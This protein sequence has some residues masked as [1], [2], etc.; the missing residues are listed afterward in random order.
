MPPTKIRTEQMKVDTD[1]TMAANSDEVV[2]SQKAVVTYV[3]GR[4]VSGPEGFGDNY[5]ISPIISANQILVTLAAITGSLLSFRIG[6]VERTTTTPPTVTVPAGVV[7][8][9]GVNDGGLPGRDVDL[10][11]YIGWRVSDTSIFLAVSRIPWAKTFA[12]VNYTAT[13]ERTAYYSGAA[14]AGSNQMECIGRI[15]AQNSGTASY[16]WSIPNPLV[17]SRPIYEAE[18][19]IWTPIMDRV[20]TNY[21]TQ[22]TLNLSQYQIRGRKC[23]ISEQH[24]QGAVP[25]G[26]GAQR[27]T[28]PFSNALSYATIIPARNNTL[29]T[30]FQGYI[31]IFAQR[32]LVFNKYDGTAEALAN[33]VYGADGEY[34]IG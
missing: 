24:T 17:I 30:A 10:F 13:S 31:N 26:T 20:T 9:M 29:L 11:I 27:M 14:P 8:I 28:L 33:N 4:F 3:G 1:G 7:N 15:C 16:N 22:P 19:R 25:G 12:D 2:P 23:K 5:V 32:T 34:W 18:P 6:D 21:T